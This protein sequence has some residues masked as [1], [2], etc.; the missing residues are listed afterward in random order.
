MEENEAENG[1]PRKTIKNEEKIEDKVQKNFYLYII[2]GFL[3]K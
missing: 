1:G 3:V 2:N